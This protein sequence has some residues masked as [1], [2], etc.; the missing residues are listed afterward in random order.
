VLNFVGKRVLQMLSQPVAHFP[1]PHLCG[2]FPN[3]FDNP[4]P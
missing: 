3:W 4:S 2:A 1:L